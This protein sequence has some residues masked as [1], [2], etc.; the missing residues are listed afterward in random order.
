MWGVVPVEDN[1]IEKPVKDIK[2]MA[3]NSLLF[4]GMLTCHSLTLIDEELCGDPLDI[5]VKKLKTFEYKK[6]D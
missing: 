4:R 1:R 3:K 5:K 2:S 6:V